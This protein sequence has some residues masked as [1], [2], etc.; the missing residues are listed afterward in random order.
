MQCCLTLILIFH[1][2]KTCIYYAENKIL[3]KNYKCLIYTL[4][5]IVNI[6][7]YS[8]Q[9]ATSAIIF[10]TGEKYFCVYFKYNFLLLLQVH[11]SRSTFTVT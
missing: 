6:L 9:L 3:L 7:F 2:V 1:T 8:Q 4:N 5:Y 10:I 11:F